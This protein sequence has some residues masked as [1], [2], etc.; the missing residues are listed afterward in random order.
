MIATA[1][2]ITTATISAGKQALFPGTSRANVSRV[3]PA[4]ER[5]PLAHASKWNRSTASPHR[6]GRFHFAFVHVNSFDQTK[7]RLQ[8][9]APK[10][11]ATILHFC[12]LNR[13]K[14]GP[15]RGWHAE[16]GADPPE[17]RGGI[18]RNFRFA[19]V[20]VLVALVFVPLAATADAQVSVGIGVGVPAA[21]PAPDPAYYG[22][23]ACAWGY[24]S[25]YPYACA[26]YGYYGP[27]WFVSGIFIGA[28]PWYGW[29]HPAYYAHPHYGY[30]YG[31]GYGY[32]G[33]YYA[34][35]SNDYAGNRGYNNGAG[36]VAGN[37]GYSGGSYAGGRSYTMPRGIAGGGFNG[38]LSGN[39]GSFSS[40]ARGGFS[41]GGMRGGIG[42]GFGGG[43][44][45]FSGGGARGGGH[46]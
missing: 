17:A 26:P 6:G 35:H 43:G 18:M 42:S 24:Y 19:L 31:A 46:R 5:F 1:A 12:C 27:S 33:G 34:G 38:G 20:A 16:G 45:G 4:S 8:N 23:P 37:R 3:E 28:G 11:T 29:G 41:S 10:P 14:A 9:L 44:H 25:Y 36:Y 7:I 32:R 2:S 40:G 13:L 21:V 15:D 30:G 39:R 22:P